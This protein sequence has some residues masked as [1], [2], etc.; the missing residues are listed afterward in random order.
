MRYNY[1]F[2]N[3]AYS[4]FILSLF[5]LLTIEAYGIVKYHEIGN[6]Q[7][8][9]LDGGYFSYEWNTPRQTLNWPSGWSQRRN[10][11]WY[12]PCV[13][14]TEDVIL[15][16]LGST[17]TYGVHPGITQENNN[18]PVSITKYVKYLPPSIDIDGERI[19]PPFTDFIVDPDLPSDEMIEIE[20]ILRGEPEQ[21]YPGMTVV[22][23]SYSYTN[24]NHDDYIIFDVN[25]IFSHAFDTLP[26]HNIPDQTLDFW[27]I[28]TY[29]FQPCERGARELDMYGY[30][31]GWYNQDDSA[32]YMIIPSIYSSTRESLVVSYGWDGDSPN[33]TGDDV[34]DPHPLTGEFLSPQYAGFTFL[35]VDSSALNSNDDPSD[36]HTVGA[37][38]MDVLWMDDEVEQV[39]M[40]TAGTFTE[41]GDILP[42]PISWQACKPYTLSKDDDLHIV[43]ALGVGGLSIESCKEYG[44]EWLA[45]TLSD[46][47]KNSLLSTGRDSLVATLQRAAWCYD[48]SLSVPEPPPSPDISVTSGPDEI[49]IEWSDVSDVPDP[50]TDVVDFAGYRVY[51][52]IGTPDTT[53]TLIY[54]GTD[55]SFVDTLVT[56]GVAYFYYV[57][58][59]DDGSQNTD[60]L[61]PGQSLESSKFL[62]RTEI[63]VHSF[64]PGKG[65]S[66]DVVVVPNPYDSEAHAVN[67][68][69]EPNK[70]LFLNLPQICTIRI[71]T[72]S[73]HLIKTIEHI[74]GSGDEPWDLITDFN[75]YVA[76]GVYIYRIDDAST[77]EGDPIES[78]FG[79]FVVIR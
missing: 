51:R 12:S 32:S 61:Y 22:Q 73:G 40:F 57:T 2:R 27:P 44:A 37:T 52:S 56:R 77:W 28:I 17:A 71:Y 29:G 26:E 48:R 42:C 43:Y 35:H 53:F 34:G 66:K 63:A 38:S 55:T 47:E 18:F 62:N 41:P 60:G 5:F 14:T 1:R 72:V 50:V 75:Q 13:L 21:G 4:I 70:I 74:S 3:V 24:Q 31:G 30:F 49:I 67:Y 69:G 8:Q 39:D 15:D 25:F 64:K 78:S 79:K 76:S 10:V 6:A 23:R 36:P 68:P 33:Y 16:T 11:V 7:I 46:T 9:I 59:F 58:A 19:T 45:G 20:F 65:T 54:E